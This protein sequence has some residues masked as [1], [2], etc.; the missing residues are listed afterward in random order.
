MHGEVLESRQLLSVAAWL[1]EGET[2][3]PV[4]DP[5]T[6][7]STEDTSTPNAGDNS[8]P[9]YGPTLPNLNPVVAQV[10]IS[11]APVQALTVTFSHDVAAAALIADGSIVSAVSLVNFL[12]GPVSLQANQFAYD[13]TARKLTLTLDQPL[14][15]GGLADGLYELRIDGSQFQDTAGRLLCGG[16]AGLRF[17]IPTFAAPAA[18]QTDGGDLQVGSYSVPS[19]ADWNGDGLLD[20]IVGEKTA[21]GEGK[22]RIY[23]NSGTNPAPVYHSFLVAQSSTGGDLSVSASGCLGVFPRVFDW[24]R[25]GRQ[26]LVLGLADGTVLVALNEN[27]VADPRFGVPLS[28]QVGPT[29]A[30]TAVDVGDR[31]TLAIVD[32]NDDGWFDLVLGGLDGKVHVLINAASAGLPDFRTDTLLLDGTS[33]LTAPSG[34]SAVAV[35]DLNGDGRKDLVLGNTDGQLLFFANVGTDATPLFAGSELLQ[36]DH[37]AVDLAGSARSRPFVDDVNKDGVPDLL[38]GAADGL[39]RLYLGS[40]SSAAGSSPTVGDPGGTYVYAFRVQPLGNANPWQNSAHP[41]DV[42]NDGLITPLDALLVANYINANGSGALTWPA[43]GANCPPPYLDCAGDWNITP[44]DAL[45]VIND[46]NTHGARAVTAA[47]GTDCADTPVCTPAGEA[48][49]LEDT[50]TALL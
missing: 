35:V 21:A 8:L 45:L 33:T 28:V 43:L 42:N 38:V 24:N 17:E 46:L 32:W 16:Q 5:G 50:L 49:D 47:S 6:G 36:A 22:L 41:L 11:S 48:E 14:P 30:K 7:S 19:L 13:Q 34:R 20:L 39:V 4:T 15:A 25:D 26:D 29:G 3:G 2:C 10:G 9:T 18:L 1:A 31:A 23:L 37:A 12:R 27:T 44:Q 40:A